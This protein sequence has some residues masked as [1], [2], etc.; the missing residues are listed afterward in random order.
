MQGKASNKVVPRRYVRFNGLFDEAEG[1]RED[2][3][4]FY[5]MSGRGI[6]RIDGKDYKASRGTMILVRT[7]QTYALRSVG[8]MV[9]YRINYTEQWQQQLFADASKAYGAMLTRDYMQLCRRE[10]GNIILHFESVDRERVE[11]LIHDIH[12]EISFKEGNWEVIFAAMMCMLFLTIFQKFR[13]SN[14]SVIKMD[15]E[16]LDYIRACSNEKLTM[17]S[18]AQECCYTPSYFSRIFREKFG[19]TVTD[20]INSCRV[21]NAK[22]LLLKTNLIGEDVGRQ[23]GFPSKSAFYKKF[24]QETGMTPKQWR[25]HHRSV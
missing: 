12:R 22:D 6:Y 15:Q 7:G 10:S 4:M 17:K 23:V 21:D 24:L 16:F 8:N 9:I 13:R 1:I 5:V 19:V 2:E 25:N 18:L 14:H 3:E 20:Y 11:W